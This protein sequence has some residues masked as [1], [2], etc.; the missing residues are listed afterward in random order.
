MIRWKQ[1]GLFGETDLQVVRRLYRDPARCRRT[2]KNEGP[3]EPR[4][5]DIHKTTTEK[6]PVVIVSIDWNKGKV[7]FQRLPKRLSKA[8]L[9]KAFSISPAGIMVPKGVAS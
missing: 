8:V 3:I 5:G 4:I 6:D 7:N 1:G 9:S 2:D